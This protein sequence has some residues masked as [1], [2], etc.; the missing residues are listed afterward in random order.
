MA[1]MATPAR[2]APAVAMVAAS[3][4]PTVET[5]NTEATV[6]KAGGEATVLADRT[7]FRLW[8]RL[9]R[10]NHASSTNP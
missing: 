9:C 4:E 10:S 6:L 8:S 1:A 3:T 5:P 7:V 2:L